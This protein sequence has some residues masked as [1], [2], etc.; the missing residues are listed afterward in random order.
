ML[1]CLLLC[2]SDKAAQGL[3]AAPV[4]VPTSNNGQV[5]LCALMPCDQANVV[6]HCRRSNRVAVHR[7]QAGGVLL[8]ASGHKSKTEHPFRLLQ[9]C[10]LL[11]G[12]AFGL[13]VAKLAHVFHV[14]IARATDAGVCICQGV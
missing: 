2:S 5:R 11:F 9:L 8:P 6:S 3:I 13:Q 12:Q 4:Q 1:G 10:L 7:Q 14:C